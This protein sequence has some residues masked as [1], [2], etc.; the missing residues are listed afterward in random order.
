MSFKITITDNDNGKVLFNEENAR[1]II[2]SVVNDDKTATLAYTA[3]NGNDLMNAIFGVDRARDAVLER[4]PKA[5]LLYG[6]KA[7]LHDEN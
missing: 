1:V 3:C 2:G 5:K 6:L 4:E 7:L